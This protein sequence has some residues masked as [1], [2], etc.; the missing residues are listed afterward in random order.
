MKR[1]NASAASGRQSAN[2][3]QEVA[4]RAARLLA[5]GHAADF[6]AAKRKAAQQLGV[7]ETANL[8]SNQEI[9]D[10]LAQHRAIFEPEHEALLRQLR[11]KSLYL[12]RL[13]AEFRPCLTGSVLSGVAGPHSDIN[14]ILYHD[15]PKSIEFFL[16]DQKIEYQHREA[17]GAHRYDDFPTLAFWFDETPVKLH[18]RPLSAERN[19]AKNEAR[20]TRAEVEKLLAAPVMA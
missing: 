9:E 14:L 20:A 6:S 15:D 19:Q 1:K 13:L 17:N 5:E 8:P 12:M 4:A 11:Q 3:R 7:T 2:I 18:L 16:I 10:A